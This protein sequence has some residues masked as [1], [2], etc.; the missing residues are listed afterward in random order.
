M[1]QYTLPYTVVDV[2]EEHR[3]LIFLCHF[4]DVYEM[5]SLNSYKNACALLE[6][7]VLCCGGLGPSNEVLEYSRRATN[8]E[9]T[10]L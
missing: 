6:R 8:V 9:T 5:A 10:A 1:Y 7:A 3:L 2:K 4:D